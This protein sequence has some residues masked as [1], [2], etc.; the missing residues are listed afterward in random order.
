[1]GEYLKHTKKMGGVQYWD[2]MSDKKSRLIYDVID[3]S[4]SFYACPV[5]K[6]SRSRMN[7]PFTIGGGDEALEKKFLAEAKKVKLY[8]LAGHRSVGGCRASVYNGMPLEGVET[9]RNFMKSFMDE[10]RK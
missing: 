4:D 1:M 5:E 3:K 2:E 9:L 7:I 6:A 8:T 10:N